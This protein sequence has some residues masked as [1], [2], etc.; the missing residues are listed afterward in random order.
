VAVIDLVL[1][2]MCAAC[3]APGWPL[4]AECTDRVGVVGPPWCGRCGRPW[5]E[6][7]PSCADCPPGVVDVARAPFLYE[8]PLARAVRGMKFSGWHALG[9]HLAG[10]MAEVAAELLP[11]DVV[12]WVPLSRRRRAR[13]GFDQAEV[14]AGAVARRLEVPVA[15]LLRRTRDTR[16]QARLGGAERRK[17]LEGAFTPTTRPPDRVLLVDDVLTTGATAAA[18]VG[19][20]KRAGAARVGVLTAARSLGGPVPARCL[21]PSGR[22]G[23][24]RGARV[25]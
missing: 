6:P 24:G 16:A 13:R 12:A 22:L 21:G 11:A 9:R 7:L 5:E 14:L 17:A 4:C 8:G 10:A 19:V 18:C 3:G 1:P 25:P 2:P 15:R 20:L 23:A